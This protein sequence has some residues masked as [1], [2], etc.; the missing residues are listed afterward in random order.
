MMSAS[1]IASRSCSTWARAA[2]AADVAIASA[3][4]IVRWRTERIVAG[5]LEQARAFAA[6]AGGR[7]RR[8][9]KRGSA[10]A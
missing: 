9:G 2:D 10:G 1:I 7:R 6:G 4:V 3:S 5:E 8:E